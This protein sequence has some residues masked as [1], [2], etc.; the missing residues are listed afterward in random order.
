MRRLTLFGL[1]LFMSMATLGANPLPARAYLRECAAPAIGNA[2]SLICF[3]LSECD[4]IQRAF[5][6]DQLTIQLLRADLI[7]ARGE[8]EPVQGWFLRAVKHPALWFGIGL[9]TGVVVTR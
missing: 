5:D 2:D 4:S 7:E 1:T 8:I 9:V 6:E 3:T